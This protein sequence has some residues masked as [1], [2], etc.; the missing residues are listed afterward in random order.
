MIFWKKPERN[1]IV[2]SVDKSKIEKEIEKLTKRKFELM[3][4][5]SEDTSWVKLRD[6]RL[7]AD[8]QNKSLKW[9][10]LGNKISALEDKL[11]PSRHSE[12]KK[13][14]AKIKKLKT[15]L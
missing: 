5:F 13:V 11:R 3:L 1:N 2:K 6:A 9:Q 12:L 8:E 7:L 10:S 15:K 14:L 4:D